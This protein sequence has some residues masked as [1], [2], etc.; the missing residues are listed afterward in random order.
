MKTQS[1]VANKN[2]KVDYIAE[3]QILICESLVEFIP[4][5]SFMELFTEIGDFVKKNNVKKLIF[6][7]RNMRIFDQ[8]SMEWYHIH[9]KSEM[10]KY[11]L[12]TYRKLLPD[13]FIFEK[14][15]ELGRQKISKENPDFDFN[16]YD[17]QYFKSLEE[18]MEK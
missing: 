5:D 10:K 1:I 9:W 12:S 18:A 8:K 4:R 14:S 11:G 17:I 16:A 6:D 7:K 13:D 3:K 2:A 15:V